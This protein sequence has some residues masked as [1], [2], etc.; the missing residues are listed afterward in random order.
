MYDPKWRAE[1]ERR[2]QWLEMLY[3]QYGRDKKDSPHHGTYTGLA[4]KYG[5]CPW[6]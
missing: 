5:K 2:V 4:D 6:E 3:R 1:D